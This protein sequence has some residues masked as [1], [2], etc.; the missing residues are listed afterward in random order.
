MFKL[1]T[2]QVKPEWIDNNGHMNIAYYTLAFDLAFDQ[3]LAEQLGMSQQTLEA[4]QCGPFAL[5][6]QYSYHAELHRDQSFYTTMAVLDYN[7]KCMHL[8]GEMYRC[9]HLGL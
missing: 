2:Q 4:M 1:D 8:Y 9:M 3:L 5:Q 7:P 6:N